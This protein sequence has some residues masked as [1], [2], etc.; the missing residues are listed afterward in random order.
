MSIVTLKKKTGAQYN[1]NS[2]SHPLF[3]LNG[4]H[5]NQGF[6][7]QTS[8]SRSLP[9]TLMRNGGYK[10][11]G[12]CCG[13]F[14]VKEIKQFSDKTIEN[15]NIVKQSVLNT[16]GLLHVGK[17]KWLWR[18][19]PVTTVKIDSNNTLNTQS[20]HITIIQKKTLQEANA[21]H[22]INDD[23]TSKLMCN[24]TKTRYAPFKNI[25]TWTKPESDFTSVSQ[26]EYLLKR[27]YSCAIIDNDKLAE[28]IQSCN[29]CVLPGN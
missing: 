8:L 24:L 27:D 19:Q 12:G 18:P 15:S 11:Y 2:V 23:P 28:N 26:S 4:T 21:C 6:I 14:P 22:I 13:N 3:A 29:K 17:Y 20:T 9:R 25:C 16:K 7:G 1:N 10:N 5:R